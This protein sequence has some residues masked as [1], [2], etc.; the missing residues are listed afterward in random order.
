MVKKNAM[1]VSTS[2]P[3]VLIILDGWGVTEDYEANAV[4]K[5]KP[6]FFDYLLKTYPSTLLQASGQSVG[7]PFGEIGNSEVGH[8][9]LG[10]GRIVKQNLYRINYD[11]ET[12]K[13]FKN[14]AFLETINHV[15]KNKSSLH[16]MGLLGTGGVHASQEH[17]HALLD[18]C[19]M[20]KMK[21]VFLHLFLDGR[22]AP[23]DSAVSF[24]ED[25]RIKM[26]K[27]KKAKIATIGGR[28]FGMDRNE[29]WKKIELAYQAIAQGKAKE[30]AEDPIK[31][32]Q[33]FYQKEIFD[34]QIP[35]VVITKNGQPVAT[36]KDNDAIIFYNFRSDRARQI[37]AAFIK[38]DFKE[39]ER[40]KIKNLKFCS[41][42]KYAAFLDTKVAFPREKVETYL[43]KTI[44]EAGLKQLHAAETEKY[45]HVTFFFNGLKE[46]PHEG[47][48][49]ILV[50]SP[51]VESYD[52]LPQMSSYEVT[53]KFMDQIR[54][55]IFHFYLINYANSDMVA[56]TG[57]MK[58]SIEAVKSIDKSLKNLIGLILKK[59]G[60]AIVTADHGN[61]EELANR[62]TG[63][64]DKEHSTYP[65]PF[66]LV[67][68]N[69][70]NTQAGVSN[71][72]LYQKPV[73]G[74]L[75]DVAPT[76]LSYLNLPPSDE[77]SGV[78]LKR[79]M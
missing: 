10:C 26:K 62:I 66:I 33:E 2:R 8:F 47:E 46:D 54:S 31:K 71:E 34:E 76:V 22:D 43:A 30:T 74:V 32:L 51:V 5:A 50:P 73:T 18:F 69:L 75:A 48:K 20:N 16:L 39:F 1:N 52:L 63:K 37:T 35:P 17:L 14:E 79:V 42:T 3:V 61:I 9:T 38:E 65:V 44:S 59:K 13:F 77:M 28:S 56:H 53:E 40:T 7:L 23:K 55:D 58:A 36:V 25:L 72:D 4:I 68:D 41:F 70:K 12:K 27:F 64:I 21:K 49:R 29:N 11:I 6:L 15:K 78:D 24:L 19:K 45:A 57:N 60:V 67:D